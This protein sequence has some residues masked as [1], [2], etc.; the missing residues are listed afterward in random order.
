ME[1][2]FKIYKVFQVLLI[3]KETKKKTNKIKKSYLKKN[4]LAKNIC[5]DK[6]SAVMSN[7]S[8]ISGS[9][10]ENRDNQTKYKAKSINLRNRRIS[11][12]KKAKKIVNLK[13]KQTFEIED[14]EDSY[15]EIGIIF[16]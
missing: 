3:T 2:L 11:N 9:I 10:V 1:I 6:L 14:D 15:L 5:A 13:I 8:N 4:P 7:K 16:V 12:T